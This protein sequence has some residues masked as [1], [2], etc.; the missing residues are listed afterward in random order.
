[1][2]GRRYFILIVIMGALTTIGPFSSDMYLPGFPAMAKD[3]KTSISDIQLSLTSYLIGVCIGQI[4]YGPLLDRF[5]RK[6]PLY[7]GLIIYVIASM[8][9]AITSSVEALILMRLFQALGG[10]V[11]MV[12]S[13]ALVRDIFPVSDTAKV[14]SLLILVVSISPMIAPTVGGFITAEYGWHYVF[15][16]LAVITALIL[17]AAYLYLPR[18]KKPDASISLRPKEVV[19]NYIAV[20]KQPQFLTYALAGGIATS[21]PFAYIAGSPD[22]FI[23]IYGVSEHEYGAIFAFIAFGIIGCTQLNHILLKKLSSEQ[24]VHIALMYQSILGVILIVGTYFNWWDK[25]TMIILIFIFLTGQGLSAPNVSALSLAPFVKHVGS[26]SALTGSFRMG[27]GALAAAAVSLFH[28]NSAMP[29]I[30]VMVSC[31]L[32]G[33][34][35]LQL[36]KRTILYKSKEENLGEEAKNIIV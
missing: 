2:K 17:A 1:M 24:I 11:G 4:I 29:M 16:I 7:I 12:A 25:L 30:A 32:I 33:L 34:L 22:V 27:F 26:A 13:Q 18:G 3:L 10:C 19:N 23:N 9:C 35:I 15:V 28:S 20:L 31:S 21:A 6:I 14:F 8:G 36:G 5:G